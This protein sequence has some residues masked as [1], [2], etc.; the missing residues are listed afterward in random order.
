MLRKATSLLLLVFLVNTVSSQINSETGLTTGEPIKLI[1]T[2]VTITPPKDYHFMED[3]SSFMNRD[4]ETS[5]SVLKN[6][7]ISYYLM[8]GAILKS[9]FTGQET[10]LLSNQE[11]PGQQGMIFVFRFKVQGINVER[12]GYVT[13]DEKSSVSISANYKQSDKATV[14]DELKKSILSVKF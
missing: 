4:K 7:S 13:G 8:V 14:V 11:V 6:D 3:V 10:K 1:H 2:G 9:D 5:I 12:M